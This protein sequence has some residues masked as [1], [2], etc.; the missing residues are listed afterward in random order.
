MF[1]IIA[2]TPSAAGQGNAQSRDHGSLLYLPVMGHSRAL[3]PRRS[4]Y[5]IAAT[6]MCIY[7]VVD[8]FYRVT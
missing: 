5:S 3:G 8:R 4:G 2:I 1:V 6:F 7:L